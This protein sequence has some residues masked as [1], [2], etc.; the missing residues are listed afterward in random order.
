MNRRHFLT[1]GLLSVAPAN[2]RA[3][4]EKSLALDDEDRLAIE[5]ISRHGKKLV[6]SGV[7]VLARIAT[8]SHE[9]LCVAG[10]FA[11]LGKL[12]TALRKA[13][14]Q[15]LPSF[16]INIDSLLV[17][18]NDRNISIVNGSVEATG[19]YHDLVRASLPELKLTDPYHVCDPRSEHF[20]T[21]DIY[22]SPETLD[23]QLSMIMRYHGLTRTNRLKPGATVMK[24]ERG[25]LDTW[26]SDELTACRITAL[27][28][29]MCGNDSLFKN[30]RLLQNVL[31]ASS[32]K[33]ALGIDI[34]QVWQR[35]QKRAYRSPLAP[36]GARFFQTLLDMTTA[37]KKAEWIR[38]VADK[39]H[40]Q[41]QGYAVFS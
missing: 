17:A 16:D 31:I 29:E 26:V 15:V 40:L 12:S 22:K 28:G 19:F 2:L 23:D 39:T 36:N 3:Q 38:K 13:G 24:L 10:D 1:L 11:D 21:V 6:L 35:F 7:G 5:I 41:L 30:T 32:V 20:A 25:L 34:R 27:V 9:S 33:T 37:N 8:G 4:T 14:W 18:R